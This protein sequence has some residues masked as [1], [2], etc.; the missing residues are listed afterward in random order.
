[1]DGHPRERGG[2]H[3]QNPG[4]AGEPAGQA[5][6]RQRWRVRPDNPRSSDGA[7][8]SVELSDLWGVSHGFARRLT[9]MGIHFPLEL[10]DADPSRVREQLGV[11]GQR[12]VLY[13]EFAYRAATWNKDRRVVAKVEWHRDE[14]FPRENFIVTNMVGGAAPVTWFY[15]GRNTA[16]QYIEGGQDRPELDTAFLPRL[17]GQPAAAATLRPGVQPG[18]LPAAAGIADERQA[19]DVHDA[20]GQAR[21][22]RMQRR[23][24]RPA[25]GLSVGG[26]G[27]PPA[28]VPGDPAAHRTAASS[29]PGPGMTATGTGIK[30]HESQGP[31]GAS[32]RGANH[33]QI[34]H[35][36]GRV[37]KPRGIYS[38]T[39]NM[40]DGHS[41]RR[42]VAWFRF[43]SEVRGPKANR[44]IPG[45]IFFRAG[46]RLLWTRVQPGNVG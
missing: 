21:Q 32:W 3:N 34:H 5:R 18:Q 6:A 45:G 13:H 23:A 42:G 40:I 14:L 35:I 4:E 37:C 36:P 25:G 12:I 27:G 44:E 22:D 41:R 31:I 28:T 7:L 16:E 24:P 46:P 30:Q 38:L 9:A 43:A 11:M 8:S 20:A 17:R 15:N 2:G 33:V 10:R 26:G 1:M 19:L 39:S 29:N